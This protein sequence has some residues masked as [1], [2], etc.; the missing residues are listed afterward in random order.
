M[1]LVTHRPASRMSARA[2]GTMR[3]LVKAGPSPGL[4]IQT[5]P[6]PRPGPGEV[7]V[8][9]HAVGI[10]GT[11]LHIE[12]WDAWAASRVQPPRVI[13]HEFCGRV[14]AVGPDARGLPVGAFVAGESHV[15]CG[16]CRRCRCGEAHICE[17]VQVI[18]IDRDGACA[19]YVTLPARNAWPTPPGI[20]RDVAAIMD[21]F[22]NAVHAALATELTGRSVVV[23]GC[24][25]IGLCAI[26]VARRAGAARIVAVDTNEYRLRLA[27]RL[28]ADHVLD[29]RTADVAGAVRA[30]TGG[31]G[32]D[33][34]LELSGSPEGLRAGFAGLRNGG[35]A[36]L[37]GLPRR[38]VELDLANEVIFK[39]LRLQGI[40]GRRIWETWY[41][42]AALLA[43]GL[44]LQPI[45]THRLPMP[46]FQDAFDL[47]RSGMC[48]KV[49]LAVEGDE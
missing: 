11:D 39:G 13:G 27:G 24:G 18:G 26:L 4:E 32:A 17:A 3:A 43:A 10:C 9:V 31:E 25:P 47:V 14:V 15:S 20:S 19:E 22:G 36:S 2:K 30:L 45:I 21:P 48:G 28:G 37:L 38:R 34:L 44:D 6:I 41:Q 46:R 42:A 16:R 40:F 49:V 5:V 33:V 29:G 7:L 23:M 12:E 35:H 1:T 8:K